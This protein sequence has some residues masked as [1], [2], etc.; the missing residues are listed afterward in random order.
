MRHR[1]SSE[2]DA[3]WHLALRLTFATVAPHALLAIGCH[4][5]G[6]R[7]GCRCAR[8]SA[9]RTTERNERRR[10]QPHAGV[11][12]LALRRRACAAIATATLQLLP[13]NFACMYRKGIRFVSVNRRRGIPLVK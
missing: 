13:V 8:H 2:V 4:C 9:E 7:A 12:P 6:F 11:K 5:V 1:G 3:P 10:Y